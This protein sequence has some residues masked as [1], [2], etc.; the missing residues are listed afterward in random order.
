MAADRDGASRPVAAVTGGASGLGRQ[1]SFD[2]ARAGFDLVLVARNPA[3]L[4]ETKAAIEAAVGRAAVET[5]VTTDLALHDE[6][7]RVADELVRR[8]RPLDVLVN[9][10]GALFGRRET[11]EDGFERTFA[12]NVLA[13]FL[14]SY[15]LAPKLA[16][17]PRARI[18]NLSSA[19]HHRQ[20]L[21]LDDLFLEHGYRPY[22]AYARSKLALLLLTR[23]FARRLRAGGPTVLAVHPGFVRTK[24]GQ[25]N[26]GALGFGFRLAVALF[27]VSVRR[28]AETPVA[29]ATGSVAGASSGSYISRGHLR[30]GSAASRDPV[31]ARRLFE[32]CRRLTG[33][34]GVELP[35]EVASSD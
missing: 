5:V 21:D 22:R 26:P 1:V 29:A 10:A 32:A 31:T 17:R 3:R 16:G 14:L 35:G 11:T 4:A 8:E 7:V 25:N 13:P 33:L 28:G 19:A 27:A 6:V 24:F 20:H 18:V 30:P 2:L 23:E 34:E 15:R 9:N 12:L